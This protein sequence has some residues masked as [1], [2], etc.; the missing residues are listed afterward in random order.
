M[1]ILYKREG[2][3]QFN[4]IREYQL[5]D[6][7]L[8]CFLSISGFQRVNNLHFSLE[9]KRQPTDSQFP[10]YRIFRFFMA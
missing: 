9:L 6:K 1:T 8:N 4:Y 2:K 7:N 10:N 5:E 3:G